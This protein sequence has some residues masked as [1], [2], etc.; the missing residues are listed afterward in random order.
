GTA[1]IT[2]TVKDADG[3]TASDSFVLTVTAV[4]HAPVAANDTYSVNEDTKLTIAAPGVL[5]NDS[6]PDAGDTRTALLVAASGPTSGTLTVNADGSFAYTPNL[7][8]NGTDSFKYQAKD[9]AGALSNSATVT[10]TVNA[11]NDL[12]TITDIVNQTVNQDTV[13]AALAFTIG[14]VETAATALTVTAASSNLTLVPAANIVFGG[15]GASR[16][17]TVTP[18]A[19]QT[20]TVTITV[21]VADGNSGT[22]SDPFVVT[23]T[24]P[25]NRAP[26]ANN[27]AYSTN[28]DTALTI[29]ANGVLGNDT[30]ADGN[31][32]TA[33]LGTGPTHGTLTLNANGSFTY[34]PAAN[35]NGPD[36]FTYKANDGALDSNIATVT[37]TVTSVNDLP[38]ISAIADQATTSGTAVGPLAVTVGDVETAAASL[39]LTAVSSNLTLVP[40]ANIVFGGSGANRTVTVTPVAGQTGTATVT[41][42]VADGNSGTASDPF[43]V[44]VTAPVPTNKP[45]VANAQSVGAATN[46]AKSIVL[47][48]S[49]PDNDPL[50]FTVVAAPT[51]GTVTGTAPNLTYTPATGYTGADSF[52]FKANDGKVDSNI[53]TVTITINAGNRAPTVGAISW[54][55]SVDPVKVNTSITGN[56]TFTDA[57]AGDT[58]TATWDWGDGTT[59]TGAV[60]DATKVVTGSHS[61]TAAKLYTVT[62]TVKDAA[63]ASATSAFQYVAVIDLLAGYETGSGSINSPAGSYTANPSLAGTA[64]ISQFTA[65][66][67]ID[68]TLGAITNT[69]RFSYSAGGFAFSSL[70]MKWLVISGNKSWLK[71][72][73]SASGV[74]DPCY[75]LVSIVD[76]TTTLDK[77]RVKIWN[78]VTGKIIY[79]NQKDGVGVS[80]PDDALAV[81]SSTSPST[82]LFLK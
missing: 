45:P 77:V 42:T 19:G 74:T 48:A 6:D 70:S 2:V 82:I 56:A 1:T 52:T 35:Y 53:A 79:D 8:F 37:I 13:A 17:V 43:V 71:G 18:A 60:N 11:V 29:A 28:E 40:A 39:T 15:S 14:D 67:G 9:A 57:D 75:F 3:G 5:G 61:Y 16:T 51:H 33:V 25:A 12:P 76:N 78:K 46:T 62:L 34:T 49:D 73:G 44:T 65:K 68:G 69:F 55:T 10:I 23:V 50:T 58:H 31:P 81:Q 72:E 27:D 59:S 63:T 26:V 36:S 32:L 24:A 7:N 64:G 21:T 22:A 80:A 38:T 20:G 66:Y 41:V 54:N 4:N 47:T 30:D